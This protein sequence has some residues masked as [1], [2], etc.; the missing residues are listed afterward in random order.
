M[1]LWFL[2]VLPSLFPFMAA[3][4]ILIDTGVVRLFSFVFA[5]AT[6]FLFA[7]PGEAAYILFASAFSGY[8]AGAA[9]ASELYGKKRLT[10]SDAQS[11]IRFTSTSGPVF[12]MGAVAAGM[13]GSPQS[14]VC[15]AAAHY[16]SAVFTG[17]VFGLFRGE[18]AGEN[19]PFGETLRRFKD[20]LARCGAFGDMLAG[21]AEKA[22]FA[23]LRIGGLIIFFS[24]VMEILSASGI[25]DAA[26]FLYS[27]LA[28]LTGLGRYSVKAMLLGSVEM[29]NGCAIASAA[30]LDLMQKLPVVSA[31]IAFGG[32]CVHMQTRSVCARNGLKLKGFMTAKSVQSF[33]AYTLCA[34]FLFLSAPAGAGAGIRGAAYTGI[35]AAALTLAAFVAI[36]ISRKIKKR[37]AALSRATPSSL[38]FRGKL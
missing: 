31:I 13:L 12:I 1:N 32:I 11:V 5:P 14:G 8:P 35:A 29:T 16:L 9:L 17:V 22:L 25:A 26:A 23:L 33:F 27:P 2:T 21:S 37:A 36:K 3:S 4:Y 15:L 28:K 34:L 20:E 7:A 10:E 6:R 18:S 30:P 19:R 38:S 24:V